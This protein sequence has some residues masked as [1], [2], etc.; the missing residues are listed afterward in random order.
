MFSI[1][2]NQLPSI[3]HQI[4]FG[5]SGDFDEWKHRFGFYILRYIGFVDKHRFGGRY[6]AHMTTNLLHIKTYLL[7]KRSTFYCLFIFCGF[8]LFFYSCPYIITSCLWHVSILTYIE[9]ICKI[10]TLK[11]SV[12][13]GRHVIYGAKLSVASIRYVW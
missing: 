7:N 1:K 3:F 10:Y 6:I 5:G 12:L 11:K 13:T 9:E 4:L 2:Q 8:V